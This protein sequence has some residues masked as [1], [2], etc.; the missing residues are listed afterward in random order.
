MSYRQSL[1]LSPA[2]GRSVADNDDDDDD[3][4]KKGTWIHTHIHGIYH[5]CVCVCVYI[6]YGRNELVYF[7]E[8]II[9]IT[10]YA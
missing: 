6:V 2:I 5:L 3:V 1:R 7:R 4:N 8:M 9:V 10:Y